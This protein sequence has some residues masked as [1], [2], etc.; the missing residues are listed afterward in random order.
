MG[1]A[2]G[3][4]RRRRREEM[5]LCNRDDQWIIV[6]PEHEVVGHGADRPPVLL[7]HFV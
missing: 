1:Q 6:R 5:V 4:H 7:E 3:G 2:L